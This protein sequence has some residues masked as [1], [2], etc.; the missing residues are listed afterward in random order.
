MRFL[1]FV[2]HSFVLD[3]SYGKSK[4]RKDEHSYDPE[5]G[6]KLQ[7]TGANNFFD[8]TSSRECVWSKNGEVILSSSTSPMSDEVD[9][10]VR[11]YPIHA[12]TVWKYVTKLKEFQGEVRT[13]PPESLNYYFKSPE[14]VKR[15]ETEL[16]GQVEVDLSRFYSIRLN[17]NILYDRRR[18]ANDTMAPSDIFSHLKVAFSDKTVAKNCSQ[19]MTQATFSGPAKDFYHKFTHL[20]LHYTISDQFST[21]IIV[22]TF[23][24][25]KNPLDMIQLHINMILAIRDLAKL[26]HVDSSDDLFI[27]GCCVVSRSILIPR[28][29]LQTGVSKGAT[30]QD[31]YSKFFE[32]KKEAFSHLEELIAEQSVAPVGNNCIIA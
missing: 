32:T 8:G 10:D 1:S 31:T 4:G 7:P 21:D 20:K 26:D 17:G 23:D 22:N 29:S 27:Q 9:I 24:K 15:G 5:R 30:I 18:N 16:S 6:V 13:I 11:G 25:D 2:C 3:R 14:M 19:L 28:E 12:D